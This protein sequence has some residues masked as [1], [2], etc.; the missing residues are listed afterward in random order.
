MIR[1]YYIGLSVLFAM[2]MAAAIAR[3]CGFDL[4]V[5]EVPLWLD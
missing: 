4:F 3:A 2:V 1:R 5:Q